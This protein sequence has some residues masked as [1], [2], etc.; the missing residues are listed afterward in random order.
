MS[1]PKRPGVFRSLLNLLTFGMAFR[2]DFSQYYAEMSEYMASQMAAPLTNE[3]EEP[4]NKKSDREKELEQEL[5][6]LQK[7][8]E[9]EKEV[10]K[11]KEL[12]KDKEVEKEKEASKSDSKEKSRAE[13]A[14]EIIRAKETGAPAKETAAPAKE[15]A[16]PAKAPVKT[17]PPKT[18]T[19]F[20]QMSET[21]KSVIASNSKQNQ[22][23]DQM[24]KE[25]YTQEAQASQKYGQLM[26]AAAEVPGLT[27]QQCTGA[28]IAMFYDKDALTAMVGKEN[29]VEVANAKMKEMI[30]EAKNG[31]P[32]RLAS[33][34]GNAIRE[35]NQESINL[36]FRYSPEYTM[37][38]HTM[39]DLKTC[40][41]I[42]GVKEAVKLSEKDQ[43]QMETAIRL[44]GVR[45]TMFGEAMNLMDH[46]QY[47]VTGAS[48][49]D[50]YARILGA[51]ILHDE[52][53]KDQTGA[54]QD[55]LINDFDGLMRECQTR[56][57]ET[58]AFHEVMKQRNSWF[59]RGNVHDVIRGNIDLDLSKKPMEMKAPTAEKAAG[60]K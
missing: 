11:E 59:I 2:R 44:G 16:A 30:E 34:L 26:Q 29:Q 46:N 42:P 14:D 49:H 50:K 28:Y 39:R 21:Q 1:K 3:K 12:E 19:N 23:F 10:E 7:E 27:K 15:T 20:N 40:L 53:Q 38:G 43:K 33:A 36:D 37:I 22:K 8:L 60:K 48:I 17:E 47:M 55:K 56:A 52:L 9:K 5:E 6:K 57:K 13:I 41:D 35:L 32:E 25:L 51:H 31:K 54:V 24:A 58:V 4:E 18:K 45:Y